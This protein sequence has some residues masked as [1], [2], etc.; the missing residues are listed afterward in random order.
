METSKLRERLAAL[1]A[2]ARE[3]TP[4]TPQG[5][6]GEIP[7]AITAAL[8]ARHDAAL[9]ALRGI[10]QLLDTAERFRVKYGARPLQIPE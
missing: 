5:G 3:T 8:E 9:V 2:E 6:Y 1:E 7:E 10:A 4:W